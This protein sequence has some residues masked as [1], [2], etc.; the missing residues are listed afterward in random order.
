MHAVNLAAGAVLRLDCPGGVE[1]VCDAGRVWITEE[2]NL[3]DLWLAA[4]QSVRL[5][6]RGLALLEAT[7]AS[8]VRIIPALAS[9]CRASRESP[10]RLA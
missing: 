5:A 10:A 3:E 8:R 1:V 4:G 6:R 7:Q 9:S 2:R